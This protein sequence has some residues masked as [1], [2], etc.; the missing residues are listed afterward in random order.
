MSSGQQTD[1][2][3]M[4][5]SK[6]FD[7]V[8]HS[9]LL[10]KL[11]YYGIRGNSLKWIQSFLTGR[12][13]RVV[14]DGKSS[15]FASVLSGVPQGTVLGPILFLLFINDLP[16]STTSRVRLFADDAIVYRNI[17]SQ[18][19]IHTLQSD[20]D[21][22]HSWE[23]NWQ[24][25]FNPDKCK[26]MH[27]TR[28]RNPFLHTYT[29]AGTSLE[30]VDT[31]T[32]L[33]VDLSAQLD[34]GPHITKIT[35]K[36]NRTLGFIKRN[37]QVGS[38]HIKEVAY[39]TLVRPS[40]EYCCTVWDP[41]QQ[42]HINQLEM[43]QRRAARFV[44]RRYHNTSSVSGMLEELG[45]EP[46][47]V[48]RAKFRLAFMYKIV[49]GLVAVPASQFLTPHT[50]D[51]RYSHNLQYFYPYAKQNYYKYTFFIRTV[52][53]WNL[54]PGAAVEASSKDAF[55]AYLASNPLP[56]IPPPWPPHLY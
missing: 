23:T 30:S 13:Q 20:L 32:Y 34:W 28:S 17:S 47:K 52:P 24:M 26:V 55:R 54:M 16:D 43:V 11:D 40:L 18:A 53:L 35:N 5:F 8:P 3:I 9:R 39:Q 25:E 41:H 48:R 51:T 6:A 22:L 45:W 14:V 19:D 36:S 29:L 56:T 31:S 12:Q 27:I 15:E 1:I 33:G 10:Q 50:S 2:V 46:L 21:H 4:D 44:T 7:K 49:H 37:L 38:Q 42:N